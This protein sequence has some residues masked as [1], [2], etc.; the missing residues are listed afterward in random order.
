MTGK[1]NFNYQDVHVGGAAKKVG[2][3]VESIYAQ[4]VVNDKSNVYWLRSNILGQDAGFGC[5][6]D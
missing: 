2:D 4:L 1:A 6:I 5:M 3:K